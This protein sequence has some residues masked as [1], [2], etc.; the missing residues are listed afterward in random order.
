MSWGRSHEAVAQRAV[1]DRVLL[2][3]D[4]KMDET[5]QRKKL[6]KREENKKYQ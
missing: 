1:D 5:K 3:R 4:I 6:L 2:V